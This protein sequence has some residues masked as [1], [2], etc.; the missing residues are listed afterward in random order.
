[1]YNLN[2]LFLT[3]EM[4][5]FNVQSFCYLLILVLITITQQ[6]QAFT[7]ELYTDLVCAQWP[8][9]ATCLLHISE[10]PKKLERVM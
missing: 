6:V 3:D 10:S 1:M 2:N 7:P 5:F 8:V 4:T 9:L